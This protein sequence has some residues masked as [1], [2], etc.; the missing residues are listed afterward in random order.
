MDDQSNS[1]Y[2]HGD[3]ICTKKESIS[4]I[5]IQCEYCINCSKNTLFYKDKFCECSCKEIKIKHNIC[6]K[7][8]S[9]RDK[10][11]ELNDELDTLTYDLVYQIKQ[12]N[13]CS[14]KINRIHNISLELRQ[15]NRKLLENLVKDTLIDIISHNVSSNSILNKTMKKQDL[16]M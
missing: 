12:F 8:A 2:Y 15:L 11:D 4:L 9:Y 1:K 14:D 5:S 10:I 6:E 13:N 7:C 3:C 16:C